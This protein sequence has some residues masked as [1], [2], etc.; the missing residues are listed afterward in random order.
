MT[1]KPT[2]FSNGDNCMLIHS[3][4][5]SNILI[6][7][8]KVSCR[9]TKRRYLSVLYILSGSD[10]KKSSRKMF[11]KKSHTVKFAQR[12]KNKKTRRKFSVSR[13]KFCVFFKS[14]TFSAFSDT[15]RERLVFYSVQYR[16]GWLAA[17][18]LFHMFRQSIK[19]YTFHYQYRC[20]KNVIHQIESKNGWLLLSA[21]FTA[22]FGLVFA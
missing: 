14:S 19:F 20:L 13:A 2:R 8:C 17:P 7:P 15:H 10:W 1:E 4:S 21:S 11:P 18:D 5:T 22:K 12:I 16:N 9:T 6:R 3:G